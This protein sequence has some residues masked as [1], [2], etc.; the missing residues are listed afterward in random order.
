MKKTIFKILS[1]ALT[2]GLLASLIIGTVP[3]GA[4]EVNSAKASPSAISATSTVTIEFTATANLS[5][6]AGKVTGYTLTNGGFGYFTAPT[7]T[8]AAPTTGVQA[9][10]TATVANGVVTGLTIT[11]PGSGYT[12]TP[13]ITIVDPDASVTALAG[14]ITFDGTAIDSIPV[15]N[16]TLN[17]YYTS[18]PTVTILGDGSGASATA[19][20]TAGRVT[21]VIVN[22]GGTG[23][24]TASATFSAPVA[25]VTATATAVVGS[26][27]ADTITVTFP[28]SFDVDSVSAMFSNGV[29]PAV[30]ASLNVGLSNADAGILV[31][32]VPVN[33]N[34]GYVWT[35]TIYN[36]GNPAM[37]GSY[38]VTVATSK[39]T[40]PK[41][42]DISIGAVNKVVVYN[43]AG[44][45]VGT[46]STLAAA[47][48]TL[49]YGFT[50]EIYAGTYSFGDNLTINAPKVT[51]KGM[52]GAVILGNI[53]VN[54]DD[55][56]V[57]DL[58]VVGEGFEITEDGDNATVKNVIFNK[59]SPPGTP[60]DEVLLYVYGNDDTITGCTFNLT[61]PAN[62]MDT[63]I[64]LYNADGALI[65]GCS[66]MVDQNVAWDA[67]YAIEIVAGDW[68]APE[69]T[70]QNNTFTG[71]SGYGVW[72]GNNNAFTIED[73][74]F[75]G[76]EVAIYCMY[77]NYP[78][79]TIS[80]NTITG[81]TVNSTNFEDAAGIYLYYV[82]YPLFIYDNNISGN[83]SYSV[84]VAGF[85]NPYDHPFINGN[86]FSDN[87][88]GIFNGENSYPLNAIGNYWGDSD[89]PGVG[90]ADV[91]DPD[92]ELVTTDPFLSVP[93][94]GAFAYLANG[95]QQ[96]PNSPAAA[97]DAGFGIKNYGYDDELGL[98]VGQTL[99]AN[100]APMEPPFPAIAY[101]DIYTSSP[102]ND[103]SQ[104][105]L[106]P[107]EALTDA[108]N[109]YYWSGDKDGWVYCSDQG[110]AGSGS[111]AWFK[112]APA[113]TPNLL[114]NETIPS[115]DELT[116][117]YFVI[118]DGIAPPD[119]NIIPSG[120]DAGA[121]TALCSIPFSWPTV[122]GATGYQIV[123]WT[124]DMNNPIVEDEVSSP[125][126][127]SGCLDAGSYFWKVYAMQGD[128]VISESA[129]NSFI[130]EAPPTTTTAPPPITITSQPP[131]TITIT[132]PPA[133]TITFQ[134]PAEEN[135]TPAWIYVIIGIGAVLVIVVI[136]LIVRTR[137]TT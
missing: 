42:A 86:N 130:A 89:G 40:T 39:E 36:V 123:I 83:A 50:A 98:I 77:S 81:G 35:L 121:T 91:I 114:G 18:P 64:Y 133:S 126:F 110:V 6:P 97:T 12:S 107:G 46:Y 17:G 128:K 20:L 85:D 118:V 26:G 30:S 60:S 38:P 25:A 37:S 137:R 103:D 53:V 90:D 24:T 71:S 116:E 84:Y 49:G 87:A 56:T 104:I 13:T 94:T 9:T 100:P 16:P 43:V 19:V 66:F 96:M 101:F 80:G 58:I 74:T 11:N 62:Y 125:G 63:G 134:P 132:Q 102:T 108:A 44:Q 45:Y 129:V 119:E 95:Y 61:S 131:A 127:M 28:T 51:V 111:Y 72:V 1:L 47:G 65:T 14:T 88:K 99:S 55:A 22:S 52:G 76:L 67:D 3:A 73:N 69:T 120:P 7:V 41:S 48:A 92:S 115:P 79:N 136:V 122:P 21:G 10:A 54:G 33:A 29:D 15:S 59:T 68:W 113:G 117:T 32:N 82:D 31:F 70:I 27:S 4:L 135:I 78:T 75:T 5:T 57:S 109:I 93:N 8:I 112:V 34:V 106:Y 23:Y 2:V 124:T 105:N